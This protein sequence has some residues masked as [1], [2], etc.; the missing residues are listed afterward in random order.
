MNTDSPCADA[1][2]ARRGDALD[3][4]LPGGL[5]R[6]TLHDVYAGA[7]DAAAAL[8][9]ALLLAVRTAAGGTIGVVRDDR[10]VREYGRLYGDGLA[11]L[12]IDPA[13]LVVVHAAD[14]TGVL[15]AAGDAVQ[16]PDLGAVVVQ[17]WAAA[18][19]FD[20]TASRRLALRLE[21]TRGFAVVVRIGVA[22]QPSAAM[23]R[24]QVRAAPS[25]ALAANAPGPPA[26]DLS[27][28][29]HRRGVAGFDT[30]LEWNRDQHRFIE[31]P[32]SRPVPAVAA[33]RAR[34]QGERRAA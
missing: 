7:E 20:L 5:A 9:F 1:S 23:T 27:L 6:G 15:R 21:R 12:G 17:P 3:R 11:A 2:P 34:D 28:L 8:G 31:P 24:W 13:G 16:C 30:R 14:V 29:R 4:R 19:A 33:G 32:L 26:F 22:P 18:P 25:T 10:A